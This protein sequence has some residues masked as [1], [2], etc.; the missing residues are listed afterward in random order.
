MQLENVRYHLGEILQLKEGV[1]IAKNT[2]GEMCEIPL[3]KFRH[4]QIVQT[5]PD[6]FSPKSFTRLLDPTYV[7][8]R[9]WVYGENYIDRHGHGGGC[10][11]S[12]DEKSFLP[13]E[14]ARDIL[15]AKRIE[16]NEKLATLRHE[17]KL[18]EAEL[19]KVE[20]GIE[21]TATNK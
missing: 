4:R 21:L 10:G 6:Y 20:Y 13:L 8:E 5:A 19:A 3:P 1:L 15:I 11:Y 16:L 12:F 14:D 9:G 18:A 2:K 7:E 17:T